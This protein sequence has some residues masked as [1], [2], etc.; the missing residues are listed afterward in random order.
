VFGCGRLSE[1]KLR[2]WKLRPLEIQVWRMR[3][4]PLFGS[5][6]FG[7]HRHLHTGTSAPKTGSG[8][9]CDD[10]TAAE[11]LRSSDDSGYTHIVPKL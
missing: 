11:V 5:F 3:A 9:N 4:L 1:E 6:T 8:R 7:T 2:P 10:V